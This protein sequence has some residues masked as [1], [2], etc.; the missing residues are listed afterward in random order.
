M[1]KLGILHLLSERFLLQSVARLRR[2]PCPVVYSAH[3]VF[4]RGY[5]MIK[6]YGQSGEQMKRP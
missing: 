4:E 6:N 2:L 3:L 5:Q 1:R